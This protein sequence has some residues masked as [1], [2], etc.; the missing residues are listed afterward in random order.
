[1]AGVVVGGPDTPTSALA[2]QL[3]GDVGLG[4]GMG[5]NK[6]GFHDAS[7]TAPGPAPFTCGNCRYMCPDATCTLVDGP[8]N[9]LVDPDDTCRL[10]EARPVIGGHSPMM[11]IDGGHEEP[12]GDEY[13]PEPDGDEPEVEVDVEAEV[14][15]EED[16]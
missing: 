16:E 1:M 3:L 12:D 6:V 9:T 7:Y 11:A 8:Y 5:R 4:M 2:S 10:F 13:E 15:D 14:D